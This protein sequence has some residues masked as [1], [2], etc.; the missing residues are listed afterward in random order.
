MQNTPRN[1]AFDA[2]QE[3]RHR[4]ESEGREARSTGIGGNEEISKTDRPQTSPKQPK[5]KS[6]NPE[7]EVGEPKSRKWYL[8]SFQM[9]R[10]NFD[11]VSDLFTLQNSISTTTGHASNIRKLGSIDEVVILSSGNTDTLYLNLKAKCPFVL[12]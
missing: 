5:R 10:S 4:S 9:K 8:D 1:A 2:S 11:N 12:P 7:A 3:I 6:G